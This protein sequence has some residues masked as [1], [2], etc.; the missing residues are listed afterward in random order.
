MSTSLL[1]PNL[2]TNPPRLEP[3]PA[4]ALWSG[5][6][7]HIP[8]VCLD[9]DGIYH[10]DPE[11]RDASG[12]LWPRISGTATGTPR[13]ADVNPFQQRKAMAELRC[14]IGMG[15]ATRSSLG[16]LW[17]LPVPEGTEDDPARDWDAGENVIEPPTC[18][19]HSRDATGRCP[20]LRKG[21]EAVWAC[22]T[23][24]VGVAGVY[25][26]PDRPQPVERTLALGDPDLAFMV[27]TALVRYL[28]AITPVDLSDPQLF[29][30]AVPCN[31]SPGDTPTV[32]C[33]ARPSPSLPS[34]SLLAR[35]RL[36][37]DPA[38][39]QTAG[40]LTQDISRLQSVKS[41]RTS[42]SAEVVEDAYHLVYASTGP[43][44]GLARTRY[45]ASDSPAGRARWDAWITPLTPS[46][47]GIRGT[48]PQVCLLSDLGREMLRALHETL[49]PCLSV[50]SVGQEI[51]RRIESGT[52]APSARIRRRALAKSLQVPASY[53]NLALVDLAA[54]GLVEIYAGG[55]FTVASASHRVSRLGRRQRIAIGATEARAA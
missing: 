1:H 12:L 2:V 11:N 40:M 24:L 52:L 33:P 8:P 30:D 51:Q 14:Q 41:R 26:P 39:A 35:R 37:A 47:Y 22:V 46:P 19:F 31:L 18:L 13:Y 54:T 43:W 9:P 5:Q 55:H 7:L 36:P 6:S 20:E 23:E 27:A 21:H 44:L 29:A 3:V 53:V 15:P 10:E 28:G 4:V 45:T 32:H 49:V 48:W 42:A 34:A 25:Y 50:G 17:L 16:V 38:V